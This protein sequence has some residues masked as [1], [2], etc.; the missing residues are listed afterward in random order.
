MGGTCLSPAPVSTSSI[1]DPALFVVT[2]PGRSV[3]CSRP[4]RSVAC[5][6]SAMLGMP[7]CQMR[8]ATLLSPRNLRSRLS[9]TLR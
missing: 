5:P 1:K 4:G 6:M 9:K 7:C 2:R 3:A 8:K